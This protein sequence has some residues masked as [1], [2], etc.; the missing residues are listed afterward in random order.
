MLLLLPAPVLVVVVAAL[1]AAAG[2]RPAAPIRLRARRRTMVQ[3]VMQVV[4]VGTTIAARRGAAAPPSGGLIWCARCRRH[5]PTRRRRITIC[6]I[7]AAATAEVAATAREEA[8]PSPSSRATSPSSFL[9][10]CATPPRYRPY[11]HHL[12]PKATATVL[13]QT[14]PRPSQQQ[15]PP[16]PR[17]IPS[18]I[19]SAPSASRRSRPW[20]PPTADRPQGSANSPASPPPCPVPTAPPNPS[21]AP[22]VR[23]SSSAV[24]P[25]TSCG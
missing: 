6:S 2:A 11:L 20:T 23:T 10:N 24:S 12:L 18:N 4:Q 17:T 3:V 5:C 21:A 15:P 9:R 13:L 7:P 8:R 19:C 1:A 16:P 25:C 22:T 14:R